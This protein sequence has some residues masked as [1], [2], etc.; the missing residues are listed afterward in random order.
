MKKY[1]VVTYCSDCGEDEKEE[2]STITEAKAAAKQYMRDG[3]EGAAI[4]N[5][6][7]K[8]WHSFYGNYLSSLY[9]QM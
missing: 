8:S 7:T 5:H 2:Y 9:V 1:Q 3:C 4:Y 6:A